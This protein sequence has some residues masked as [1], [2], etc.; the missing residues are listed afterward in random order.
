[1]TESFSNLSQSGNDHLKWQ[2]SLRRFKEKIAQ[3]LWAIPSI[4]EAEKEMLFKEY[5]S[6]LD[7]FEE[8]VGQLLDEVKSKRGAAFEENE[9]LRSLLGIPEDE[10]RNRVLALEIDL[11]S[12][13]NRLEETKEVLKNISDR[14]VDSEEENKTLRERIQQMKSKTDDERVKG[15]RQREDDLK[16]YSEEQEKLKIHLKDLESR[17]GNMK[18]LFAENNQQLIVEKQN[19]ISVL[20]KSLLEEMETTLR[21]K[22]SLMWKEEELFAKGVAH[23]VRTALV[24]AQGQLYLTLER[25]GVMDPETKSE[26]FIKGRLKLLI[27]G[28]GELTQSFKSI[29]SLLQ[30]VTSTLDDYLHLTGKKGNVQEAVDLKSMIQSLIA[31]LYVDRLP[32]LRIEFLSDDPLPT[33]LGDPELLKFSFS[34]MIRNAIEALPGQSGEVSVHLKNVSHEGLV[35]VL[36][37][38][39]GR[40]IPDH[41][42]PRLFEP[43]LTTK[44]GRQ[45][46]NL[47]RAKRYINLHGGEIELVQTSDS[48]TLFQVQLP[49]KGSQPWP[50]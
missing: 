50:K 28:T 3:R 48:G 18:S 12:A 25:L 6:D 39:S 47:S 2:Q 24:S 27:E 35:R 10:L 21:K 17:L 16:Y 43:F 38:D 30:E 13:M 20:Q 46:L 42:I 44:E 41:L 34:S 40:G 15:L 31:E 26:A 8:E 11:K 14:F 1:M 33:I 36:I 22:Q 5:L 4:S 32:S 7:H 23:K 29:S 9:L 19:E 49:L 45:G 37:R